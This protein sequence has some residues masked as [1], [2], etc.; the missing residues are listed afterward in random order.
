MPH[1]PYALFTY[2]TCAM[3]STHHVTLSSQILSYISTSISI[4]PVNCER[5]NATIVSSY[6]STTHIF[7]LTST[8]NFSDNQTSILTLYPLS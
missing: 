2:I 1:F 7:L 8:S 5:C 3:S 6:M 4:S